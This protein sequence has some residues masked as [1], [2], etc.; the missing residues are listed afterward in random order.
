MTRHKSKTK[1]LQTS[2]RRVRILWYFLGIL[3]I[4]PAGY[5][6]ADWWTG[7][8]AGTQAIFVGG[9]SCIECHQPQAKSWTGSHHD[10]AMDLATD[11]TVLGDFQDASLEHF[12]IVSRMFRDGKRFMVHTEG[13]DGKMSDFEV[14][15]VFGV[16]PLQ[17]YMVEFDRP[18]DMPEN[19][20]ARLQVL[21]LSWDTE[22]K[23]W[24]YLSPPDVKEKL[25]HDDPLHW[26]RAGQNWNHMCAS[27]HSTNLRKNFDLAT[28][29][30]HTTFSDIDVNCESCHGP[31]SIHVE[32]ANANS[33]FWDRNLGFGLRKIK[34]QANTVEVETCAPCHSRRRVVCPSQQLDST[35]YDCYVNELL[36]PETYYADGQVKDE[37]YVYGSFLQSKMYHKGVRCTDCHDPH[38]VQLKHD[39]NKVCTSCHQH[40]AAKY[41]TPGHHRHKAGSTGAQCVECHMPETPF[42]KVDFRRDH[43]IRVPRPDLSVK[44]Q[45]PNACTGCHLEKNNVRERLRGTLNHYSD[46]LANRDDEPEIH[47]E[48]ERVDQWSAEWLAEWYKPQP[49]HFAETFAAAWNDELDDPDRL[50]R[51]ALSRAFPGITRASALL[52]LARQPNVNAM[53]VAVRFLK[54]RDPQL[55]IVAINYL[56]SANREVLL[57]HIQPQLGAKERS[58]RIEAARALANVPLSAL[59]DRYK[60]IQLDSL[61]LYRQGLLQDSDQSASNLSLG[62]LEERLSA[63]AR[64]LGDQQQ[65]MEHIRNAVRHYRNAIKVQPDVTGPRS[66]LVSILEQFGEAEEVARLR[67]EELKLMKRDARLAPDEPTVQYRYGLL[68]Y[69][70][71]DMEKAEVALARAC[72]L[73]PKNTVFRQ[74][75]A[76]LYH[77]LGKRDEAI[78]EARELLR[79]RPNDQSF[80]AILQE[81]SQ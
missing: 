27:C 7:V 39:G 61:E 80:H 18:N 72:D 33:L 71:G 48:L 50:K 77:K 53:D 43:S 55:R 49:E 8:P 81:V 40:P 5:L 13:P 4:L 79:Q 22:K 10:L 19:E 15:Y 24:F 70:T 52:E 12:G 26:T 57:E 65:Y 64:E 11:E 29:T 30:Y 75:L 34:G 44:L 66:N 45:T 36:R 2:K 59:S 69:L 41:D 51:L 62:I 16:E 74:A 47:A 68:L 38:S 63:A 32:L 23:E 1:S 9:T 56:E 46:W 6:L 14:K 58:V 60:Q 37:V 73:A 25:A 78:R 54:D 3:P 21:R 31:G 20:I 76:L 42:M 17:Q 35:Y 28:T 67:A